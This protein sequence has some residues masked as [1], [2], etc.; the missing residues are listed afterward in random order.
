MATY[1][2]N[3]LRELL[4]VW[5]QYAAIGIACIPVTLALYLIGQWRTGVRMLL[6]NH[7][8]VGVLFVF[9]LLLSYYIW[10]K[11]RSLLPRN[12]KPITP[13]IFISHYGGQKKGAR[14]LPNQLS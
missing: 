11:L 4:S 3:W 12:F 2:R 5:L 6:N 13:Q 9:T 8:V 10:K 7:L 1:L 14:R